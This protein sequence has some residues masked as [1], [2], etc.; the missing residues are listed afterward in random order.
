[1]NDETNGR[2]ARKFGLWIAVILGLTLCSGC[3]TIVSHGLAKG[4]PPPYAGTYI[5]S[6]LIKDAGSEAASDGTGP[7]IIVVVYGVIDFPFSLVADTLCL[8]YDL[9]VAE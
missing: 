4:A 1:M 3:S 7:A 2:Y 5:N 9:A 6:H 8:P